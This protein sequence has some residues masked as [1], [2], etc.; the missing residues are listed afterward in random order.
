[1]SRKKTYSPGQKVPISG[2][3]KEPGSSSEITGVKEKRL[4]PTKR[5]NSGF[6]LV[7]ATKHPK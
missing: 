5:P 2:Q 1:M 6:V 3:Y 7:D 4:P